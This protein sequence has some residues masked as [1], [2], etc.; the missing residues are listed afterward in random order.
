MMKSSGKIIETVDGSIWML[1]IRRL[2]ATAINVATRARQKMLATVS[3][4]IQL[5]Y[6]VH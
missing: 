1:H 4:P 2:L 3:I 5:G 6:D